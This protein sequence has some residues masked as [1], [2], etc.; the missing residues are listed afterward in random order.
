MIAADRPRTRPR[1]FDT[2][3]GPVPGRGASTWSPRGRWRR[4]SSREAPDLH[5]GNQVCPADLDGDGEVGVTDLIVLLAAWGTDPGGPPDFDGD[6]NVGIT[7]LIELLRRW[8]PCPGSDLPCG[9]ADA[10]SCFQANGSPGC[11]DLACCQTVCAIAPD[12]CDVA[13]DVSCKDLANKLCA[14]CGDAGSGDCCQK[15]GNGSP[16]CD[17]LACCRLVCEQLDPFCCETEWDWL[18]AQQANQVCSCE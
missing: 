3:L 16:G 7:D 4:R 9:A 5:F 14:G 18:C 2:P 15:G 6:G 11:D 8:G 1:S 17:D 12:C 10:G 13:W